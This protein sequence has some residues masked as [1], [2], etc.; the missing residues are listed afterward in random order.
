MLFMSEIKG[1]I[2]LIIKLGIYIYLMSKFII[3][4]KNKLM[5]LIF[6]CYKSRKGVIKK[7]MM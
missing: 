5:I 4:I 7:G 6:F 2:D 3:G 1:N